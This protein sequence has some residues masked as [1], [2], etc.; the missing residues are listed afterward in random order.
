MVNIAGDFYRQSLRAARALGRR[1]VLLV[2]PGGDLGA[3]NG[4]DAIA[5]PYAPYSLLF[6][7]AAAVVPV[8]YT[9]LRAHET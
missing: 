6:P 5:V 3:A 9:H 1:S 2:G 7:R 4:P 8:S